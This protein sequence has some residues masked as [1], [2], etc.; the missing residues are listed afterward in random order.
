MPSFVHAFAAASLLSAAFLAPPFAQSTPAVAQSVQRD[1]GYKVGNRTLRCGR[2]PTLFDRNLPMEGA[3]IMGEA[4]VLNPVMLERHPELVRIFVYHHECG[5][6]RVGGSELRADC[7]AVNEGVRDGWLD[8]EALKAVCRSFGD[9]PASFSHPSGKQR[10]KNIDKCF[11]KASAAPR[12]APD[13]TASTTASTPPLP[14]KA[15]RLVREPSLVAEGMTRSPSPRIATCPA[16]AAQP[17]SAVTS[18]KASG[19]CE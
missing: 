17:S 9:E 10:C 15:Y 5:H 7:H 6:H 1:G 8:R 3:A 19:A 14:R 13:V 11:V 2:V 18:V 4:V 16:P 12:R